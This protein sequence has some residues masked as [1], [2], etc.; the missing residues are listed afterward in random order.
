MTTKTS[1]YAKFQKSDWTEITND[2]IENHPL[3]EQEIVSFCLTAWQNIFSSSIGQHKIGEHIFP[4]PQMIGQ[5]LHELIP[6]EIAARYPDVWRR[7]QEKDD[8]D[9]V[10]LPN[11]LY[12]VELKTSSNPSQIFGNRSYAQAPSQQKKSKDGYYLAVNFEQIKEK[13]KQPRILMIRFGWLDHTDW[14]GQTAAT[15]QQ[16]RLAPETYELKLKTLYSKR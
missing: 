10:Y 7:E 11:D 1:P 13:T 12:S 9:I 2:L 4:T 14:I 15:G 8:K 6:V 16:A 5:L 3:T